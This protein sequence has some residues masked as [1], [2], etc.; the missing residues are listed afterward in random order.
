MSSCGKALDI[1]AE[2]GPGRYFIDVNPS[3]II[4]TV[5]PQQDIY[6]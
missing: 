3:T 4:N 5:M 2:F 1:Y 6:D